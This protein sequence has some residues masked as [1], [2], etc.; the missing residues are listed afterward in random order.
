[1]TLHNSTNDLLEQTKS[2]EPWIIDVRRRLHQC[3]E[4]LYE[5]HE[6]SNIVRQTLD[7]LDIEYKAGIAETGILAT[8]G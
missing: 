7:S 3:P 8:I 5:L 1:M 6:T 2:I 4:L